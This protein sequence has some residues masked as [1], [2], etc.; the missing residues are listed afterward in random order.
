MKVTLSKGATVYVDFYVK[1]RRR[2][3][4]ITI[5]EITDA[6]WSDGSSEPT[7]NGKTGTLLL[8]RGVAYC[9]RKDRYNKV[10]GKA[11]AL[12]RAM[13][14]WSTMNRITDRPTRMEIWKTFDKHFSRS[15]DMERM[16]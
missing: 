11:K 4:P 16:R 15:P 3:N 14:N 12:S 2:S 1:H 5:C 13:Q 10:L 7:G 6:C 8:G 9:C